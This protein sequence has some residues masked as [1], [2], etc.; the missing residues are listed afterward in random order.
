MVRKSKRGITPE[1][2][3][4]D[5]LTSYLS[6]SSPNYEP[7]LWAFHHEIRRRLYELCLNEGRDTEHEPENIDTDK[8]TPS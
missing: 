8:D 5:V 7:T 4:N 2:Y 3:V 1:Q 6:R